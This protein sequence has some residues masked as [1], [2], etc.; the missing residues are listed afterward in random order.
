MKYLFLLMCVAGL[1][2]GSA[3][4]QEVSVDQFAAGVK[5]KDVQVLDVR[6]PGEHQKGFIAHSLLADWMDKEEFK[7]R[8]SFLDKSRPVYVYCASGG[9]SS[10]AGKWLRNNGFTNIVELK[11]GFTAW[12]AQDQPYE[13]IEN[14]GSMSKEEYKSLIGSGK[15]VLVDFGAPWC[16]PCKKMEPVLA[17]LEKQLDKGSKLVRV[18][19]DDAT[20]IMKT[21][22]VESLPTFI[23]YKDGKES[24]RKEGVASLEELKSRL[25]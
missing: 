14:T 13:A 10:A 8:V 1:A 16:P 12:K 7:R 17:K 18:N 21:L 11:G 2:C 23:V 19:A 6:T 25:N 3:Q 5:N 15:T 24:W 9:R 4:S 20:E 22:K